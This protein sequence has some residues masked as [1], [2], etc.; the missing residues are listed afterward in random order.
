[1]K[2]IQISVRNSLFTFSL[3]AIPLQAHC[4]HPA[5]QLCRYLIQNHILL[6]LIKGMGILAAIP[7]AP[8][9][10]IPRTRSFPPLRAMRL[11]LTS[12]C[13]KNIIFVIS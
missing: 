7:P 11:P 4:K 10:T 8:S 5:L 13:R 9:M 3:T 2:T 6:A 1:M 12:P